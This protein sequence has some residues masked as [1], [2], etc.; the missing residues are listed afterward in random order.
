MGHVNL[1]CSDGLHEGR[2]TCQ[3]VF[4]ISFDQSQ[5]IAVIHLIAVQLIEK[6]SDECVVLQEESQYGSA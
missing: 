2:L 4:C 5:G 1:L 6:V 3:G